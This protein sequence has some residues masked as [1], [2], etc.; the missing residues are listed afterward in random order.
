MAHPSQHDL[1]RY[2]LGDMRHD[3]EI[4]RVKA[5]CAICF[6][7]ACI[8][9]RMFDMIEAASL[10]ATAQCPDSTAGRVATD[11]LWRRLF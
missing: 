8:A 1:E 5:H 6:R 10:A 11:D 7:C 3:S 4:A 9:D 2:C